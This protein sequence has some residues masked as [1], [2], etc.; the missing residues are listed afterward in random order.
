MSPDLHEREHVGSVDS[1]VSFLHE[2]RSAEIS[3]LTVL[4]DSA[5]VLPA[6]LGQMTAGIPHPGNESQPLGTEPEGRP[7]F[8]INL[9]GVLIHSLCSPL[10]P[11]TSSYPSAAIFLAWHFR[12]AS[13]GLR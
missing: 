12:T 8:S 11:L 5:H 13:N 1:R 6:V 10:A 4:A 9:P 3:A 7:G 2:T